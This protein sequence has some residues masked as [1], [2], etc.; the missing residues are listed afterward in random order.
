MKILDLLFGC[1]HLNRSNIY[2]VDKEVGP[3]QICLDC[4]ARRKYVF[5][6][7]NGGK[8]PWRKTKPEKL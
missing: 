8:E 2:T 1:Q 4:G 6:K 7:R 5:G 3:E